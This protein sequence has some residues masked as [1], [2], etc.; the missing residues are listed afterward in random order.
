MIGFR[1]AELSLDPSISSLER[2]YIR[3]LGVPIN[4]LRIRL[5]RVLPAT[6]GDYGSILDAGCGRGV[7]SMELAKLHP[8][9]RV[10]GVDIDEDAVERAQVIATRARIKNCE[11]RLG[12]VTRLE[13]DSEF[14]LVVCVDNLEHIDED[15]TAMRSFARALKPG[16]TLVVH[17]PGYY[18][19]WLMF[20]KRVNFDVPGHMRP[21][22]KKEEITRKLQLAGLE[23]LDA[24]Y[25]YGMLE[26][27]TNNISYLISRAEQRNRV[28]YAALF[29]FLLG[30]SYVGKFSQ[31]SWGAGVMVTARRRASED[32]STVDAERPDRRETGTE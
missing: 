32:P 23:V 21:G 22:Y 4:G 1:G 15:V 31:P 24:R 16:G 17:V 13:F 8:D 26:T 3:C 20:G 18:R 10:V 12:D 25:T 30:V 5:R 14:D 27:F 2:L 29:P 7:F 19:R 11:F 9:A 28:L 6:V